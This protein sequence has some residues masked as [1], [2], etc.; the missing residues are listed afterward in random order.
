MEI[1]VLENG[2]QIPVQQWAGVRVLTMEEISNLQNRSVNSVHTVFARTKHLLIEN[3]DYFKLEGSDA[4]KFHEQNANDKKDSTKVR[5]VLLIT[6]SG[7]TKLAMH[8]RGA[9]EVAVQK[10]INTAYFANTG[11]QRLEQHAVQQ[12]SFNK[13]IEAAFTSVM[14]RTC[15]NAEDLKVVMKDIA[16]LKAMIT[17]INNGT[18]AIPRYSNVQRNMQPQITQINT[19]NWREFTRRIVSVAA[20]KSN[21]TYEDIYIELYQNLC[22]STGIRLNVRLMN[23]KKRN[24]KTTILDVIASDKKLIVAFIAVLANFAARCNINI[25]LNKTKSNTQQNIE[26]RKA[27]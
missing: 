24:P 16:D 20:K 11:L 7:Y 19:A 1:C 25:N 22:E 8:M 10:L 6:G 18:H 4:I 9:K 2:V 26:N 3:I 15:A 17:S 5:S 12:A 27:S 23:A 13:K 21:S 14:S